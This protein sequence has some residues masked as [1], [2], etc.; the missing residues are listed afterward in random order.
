MRSIIL[1]VLVAALS[2]CA[3]VPA[4][5]GILVEKAAQAADETATTAEVVN[6]RGRTS[7]NLMRTFLHWPEGWAA[8][9]TLCGYNAATAAPGGPPALPLPEQP[10]PAP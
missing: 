9:L 8:W 5:R 1:V 4:Y 2:A 3:Q 10:G 6:C 7:G